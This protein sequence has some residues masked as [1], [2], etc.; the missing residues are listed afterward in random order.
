MYHRIDTLSR[1]RQAF[2]HGPFTETW[3]LYSL[4][5]KRSR[6]CVDSAAI[7]AHRLGCSMHNLRFRVRLHEPVSC[8]TGL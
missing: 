8:A 3:A 5:D 1:L 6:I 7:I 2:H 4:F